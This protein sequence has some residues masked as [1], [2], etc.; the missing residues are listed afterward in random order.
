M[1]KYTDEYGNVKFVNNNKHNKKV[2][3]L[4]DL[5]GDT[6]LE[7][8]IGKNCTKEEMNQALPDFEIVSDLLAKTYSFN[9]KLNTGTYEGRL[10]KNEMKVCNDMWDK[11]TKLKERIKNG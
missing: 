3:K 5:V 2:A 10:T 9:E 4:H 1:N 7:L 11:Y 8:E 6:N